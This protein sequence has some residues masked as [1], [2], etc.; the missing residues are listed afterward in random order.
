MA[1]NLITAP[2]VEYDISEMANI[3]RLADHSVIWAGLKLAYQPERLPIPE[4][5][6]IRTVGASDRGIAAISE[7]NEIYTRG[8]FFDTS[9][10][11]TED[12]G[13]GL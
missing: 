6:K 8:K 10:K 1:D 4:G 3:C 9:K 2:I 13:T 11:F 5:V 12:L 7:D